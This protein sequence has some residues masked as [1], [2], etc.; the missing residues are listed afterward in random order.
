VNAD[1]TRSDG[2]PLT[3]EKIEELVRA[4]EARTDRDE[5]VQM[6]RLIADA[7]EVMVRGSAEVPDG[8][9]LVMEIP[10]LIGIGGPRTVLVACRPEV[11]DKVAATVDQVRREAAE[12]RAKVG[13]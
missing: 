8:Q 6:A 1:P 12:F 11:L 4:L 3:A 13:L 9:L 7:D 5:W 10:D 2:P